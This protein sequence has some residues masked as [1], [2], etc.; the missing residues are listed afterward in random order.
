MSGTTVANGRGVAEGLVSVGEWGVTCGEDAAGRCSSAGG[1]GVVG[2][3]GGSVASRGAPE[4]WGGGACGTVEPGGE[5]VAKG[6]GDTRPCTEAAS[7]LAGVACGGRRVCSP[8]DLGCEVCAGARGVP[9]AKAPERAGED[10]GVAL[11]P[12]GREAGFWRPP[13]ALGR[14]LAAGLGS[15]ALCSVA[16]L[17]DFL[18]SSLGGRGRALEAGRGSPASA[19]TALDLRAVAGEEAPEVGPEESGDKAEDPKCQMPPG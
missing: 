12:R 6:G 4:T 13:P 17:T 7:F 15:V 10:S 16:L 1:G 9:R 2:G 18:G 8:L 19:P 11:E 5:D 3:E 14:L